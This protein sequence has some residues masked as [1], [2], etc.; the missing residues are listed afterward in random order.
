MYGNLQKAGVHPGMPKQ[1]EENWTAPVAC[2]LHH[3]C[4]VSNYFLNPKSNLVSIGLAT[5]LA[6]FK[7]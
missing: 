6:C 2:V 5:D 1:K 7:I 3:V 4:T